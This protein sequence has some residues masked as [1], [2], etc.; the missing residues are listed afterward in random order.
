MKPVAVGIFFFLFILVI[1]SVDLVLDAAESEADSHLWIEL[2]TVFSALTGLGTLVR[3]IYKQ[4]QELQT[5][6]RELSSTQT[7]LRQTKRKTEKLTEDLSKNIQT[8]FNAWSLTPSEKEVALLLLKGL[9][10][11]EVATVRETKEKTVRQQAS[12]LYKKAS[13][14][15]R[16]E[17]VSYFFEDFLG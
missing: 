17:L 8:Q 4:N 3:Y 9:T 11:E 5:I 13:L 7:S 12:N 2:L 10:L 1:S 6:R 15:G 16:H 14:A